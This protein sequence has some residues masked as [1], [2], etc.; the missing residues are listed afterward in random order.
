MFIV[1]AGGNTGLTIKS[2][3]FLFDYI[4]KVNDQVFN[5]RVE[6]EYILYLKRRCYS[7]KGF[8]TNRK[9]INMKNG[10]LRI[11]DQKL[12]EHTPKLRSTIQLLFSYDPKA[13]CPKFREFLSDL[14]LGDEEVIS[15]VQELLGYCMSSDMEAQKFFI[16]HGGGSNGKSVFCDILRCLVGEENCSALPIRELSQKFSLADL[17]GKLV[18]VSTEN[19]EDKGKTYNSQQIKAITGGDTLKAERK[20]KDI[21]S[22]K[23]VCKLLFAANNLPVF[24]DTSYGFYR[25]IMVIPFEATSRKEDGSADIHILRKLKAELPGIFNFALEGLMRLRSNDY[26]FSTSEKIEKCSCEYG[27][28][29]NP[30]MDFVN[31]SI[32]I[33]DDISDTVKRTDV[34][35][36]FRKWAE[37]NDHSELCGI[38]GQELWSK[39]NPIFRQRS[40]NFRA[41]KRGGIWYID[42]IK[43]II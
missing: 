14:F 8:N 32:E 21:F 3:V 1:M 11:E 42:G 7:D 17:D 25:R 2:R 33:T 34:S 37:D 15:V 30:Y 16:L 19:E 10:T 23:P 40:K 5:P 9:Y 18:N 13:K 22:L 38:S 35:A 31:D 6:R 43:M 20:H 27:R 36:A 24:N 39:L 4:E 26:Q 41:K 29:I 28:R 12:C